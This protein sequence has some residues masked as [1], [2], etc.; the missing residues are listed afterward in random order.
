MKL[1]PELK[2]GLTAVAMLTLFMTVVVWLI[3]DWIRERE[4]RKRRLYK[5]RPKGQRLLHPDVP[6]VV[7][8]S[9]GDTGM[10]VRLHNG[11]IT[12]VAIEPSSPAS[13]AG[14]RPGFIIEDISGVSIKKLRT[15]L[16]TGGL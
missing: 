4:K 6:A 7:T 9:I 15:R 13:K 14:L 12:I 5:N 11:K 10:T 1:P 2:L 3:R 8:E 16:E